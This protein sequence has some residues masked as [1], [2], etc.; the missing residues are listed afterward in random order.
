MQGVWGRAVL[1]IAG[2]AW[3][4]QHQNS[5]PP[6]PAKQDCASPSAGV[7]GA[8][9]AAAGDE[10]RQITFYRDILPILTSNTKGK[11]YKCTTCHS[12]YAKPEDVASV[13][14]VEAIVASLKSGKMPRAGNAVAPGE[15]E[16]FTKW[17]LM[18]FQTGKKAD[19]QPLVGGCN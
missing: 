2:L 1:I 8:S 16:L 11:V 12:Q 6:E 18:G 4:C 19:F 9:Q 13:D 3:A 17:R 10:D 7:A 5:I 14:E 15:I